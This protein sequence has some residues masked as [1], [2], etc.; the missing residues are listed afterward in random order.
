MIKEMAVISG[1]GG[2]GKT[3]IVGSLA[4]LAENKVLVDCDV[5]AADLRL[6][7]KGKNNRS[8][9]FIGSQKAR[10]IPD[11]CDN[12]GICVDYC[13]FDAILEKT[14]N[15][16]EFEAQ[17]YIDK[18]SC[19]GC[20]VCSD[21]CPG[22]AIIMEDHVSGRWFVNDT[23]YGPLIHAQ[24]GIAEANSGRLVSLLRKT[25]Q[26]LAVKEKHELIIIDGS[27]GIGCPV[28]A[29]LTGANYTLIVTEP[30]VS[31]IHDMERLIELTRHFSIPAGICINK[32][33]INENLSNEIERRSRSKKIPVLSRIPYDTDIIRSQIEGVPY[34]EYAGDGAAK[35]VHKLWRN[36]GKELKATVNNHKN[37]K[38]KFI[39]LNKGP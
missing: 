23:K 21:F 26:D 19:E 5:D 9:E 28:I 11:K 31:A 38:G 36:L 16:S 20:G 30:T 22:E 39:N 33:D 12:C 8:N 35:D 10:I 27:P 17:Y 6:I 4:Y 15:A 18:L 3:S 13:R 34:P 2:T 14:G 1:K 24:L 25:A 37:G 32:Y 7:L 29:S